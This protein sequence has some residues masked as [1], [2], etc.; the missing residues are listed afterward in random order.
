MRNVSRALGLILA[1]EQTSWNSL[2]DLER[3]EELQFRQSFD[4]VIAAAGLEVSPDVDDDNKAVDFY[5]TLLVWLLSEAKQSSYPADEIAVLMLS[6]PDGLVRH[7][8]V[9]HLLKSWPDSDLVY[10]VNSMK[11]IQYSGKKVE[12]TVMQSLRSLLLKIKVRLR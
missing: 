9:Q 11:G 6:L 7:H 8:R 2:R 4:L 10:I 1:G 12:L 5:A 3:S